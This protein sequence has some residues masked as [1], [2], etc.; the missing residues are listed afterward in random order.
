MISVH[1][2]KKKPFITTRELCQ[3]ALGTALITVCAWIAIPAQVPF[4]LQTF[5]VF[6]TAGLLCRKCSFL[7]VVVYLMLGAVGLPVFS[8]FRGG[9]GILFGVTGGYLIGFLFTSLTISTLTHRF[10]QRLPVLIGSMVL[11]LLLCYTFGSVWFL[12]LYTRSSDPVSL[13][14]VI[15][16]CIIPFL[17]VDAVKI[18]LA[19]LLVRKLNPLL[20]Q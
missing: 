7:S 17:P 16:M 10:G 12:V 14:T 6:L 5:A 3:T 20:R 19:S 9:P 1:A 8:G 2:P 18:L 11:G 15:G 4:T 13:G